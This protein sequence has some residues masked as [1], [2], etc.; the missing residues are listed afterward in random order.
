MFLVHYPYYLT[1]YEPSKNNIDTLARAPGGQMQGAATQAMR[2]HRRG[3]A[4]QQMSARRRNPLGSGSEG[5]AA[6]GLRGL[7]Q[8]PS[9]RIA[10]TWT[11]IFYYYF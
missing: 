5:P 11:A 2:G 7:G 10:K 4:T 8:A 1:A 3:A 6:W 9:C